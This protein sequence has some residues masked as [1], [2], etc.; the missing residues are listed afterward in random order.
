MRATLAALLALAAAV[1]GA[2]DRLAR[3]TELCHPHPPPFSVGHFN[4]T[5]TLMPTLLR[6]NRFVLVAVSSSNLP[7]ARLCPF[8]SSVE[9]LLAFF[10][11]RLRLTRLDCAEDHW[12]RECAEE[13]PAQLDFPRYVLY[14]DRRRFALSRSHYF[15]GLVLQIHKL[16]GEGGWLDAVLPLASKETDSDK[17]LDRLLDRLWQARRDY[18]GRL[19]DR[20]VVLGV[21]PEA[22][23]GSEALR[24]LFRQTA[25]KLLWRTDVRFVETGDSR[26]A[27]RLRLRRPELF[28]GQPGL[29]TVA[30]IK[31]QNRFDSADEVSVFNRS[32]RLPLEAWL[33][34]HLLALVDE[35]TWHNQDSFNNEMPLLV[36][37]LDP[38]ADRR[39]NLEYL[40]GY[41]QLARTY[42]YK[43]NFVWCDFQDNRRLMKLLG[44]EAFR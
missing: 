13:D 15:G 27:E 8:E 41:R 11:D 19:V 31:L 23:N 32:A 38:A 34:E 43:M 28:A 40:E 5:R 1:R 17:D 26:L 9:A 35:L 16:I 2:C 7:L 21:F 30:V 4:L 44:V 20:T 24:R 39:R 22:R 14:V 33:I 42:L 3:T 12:S 10:G 6:Q 37:F 29:N 25:L 36:L 18:S